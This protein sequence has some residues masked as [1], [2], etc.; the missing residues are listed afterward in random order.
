MTKPF[1]FEN[2]GIQHIYSD[3]IPV[4]GNPLKLDFTKSDVTATMRAYTNLLVCWK[5]ER[6]RRQRFGQATFYRRINTLRLPVGTQ[7]LA[8]R[9][10]PDVSQEWKGSPGGAIQDWIYRYLL[11]L[12]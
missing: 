1:N 7:F 6:R 8:S 11:F 3:R 9:R 4:G 10:L 5:T 12:C 2:C